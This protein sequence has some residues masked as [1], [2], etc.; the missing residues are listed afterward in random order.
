MISKTQ[1]FFLIASVCLKIVSSQDVN[2]NTVEGG[3]SAE[4]VDADTYKIYTFLGVAFILG[5]IVIDLWCCVS[6]KKKDHS[7]LPY[8]LIPTETEKR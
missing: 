8:Y 5:L 3:V 6:T 4:N 2:K 1:K 7:E